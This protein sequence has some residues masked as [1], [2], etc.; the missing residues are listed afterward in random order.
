MP[1]LRRLWGSPGG[2]VATAQTLAANALILSINMLTGIITARALGP[3]GRGE[4]A[5][6]TMWPQLLAMT[7]TLGWPHALIYHLKRSPADSS[8]LFS[9]ALLLATGLGL[10]S[11]VAGIG[12]LPFWLRQYPMPVIRFA[13][14]VMLAAPLGQLTLLTTA[15]LQAREQFVALNRM[16]YLTPLASLVVLSALA[17]TRRLTPFTSVLAILLPGV[18]IL[19][20]MLALLCRLYRPRWHGLRNAY[21]QL[22]HY[23]M[24][25]YG[26]DLL[27]TLGD[28]VDQ[29]IVVGL[30]APAQMGMYVVALSLSRI[31]QLSHSAITWVLFPKAIGL[32]ADEV[33]ALTGRAARASIGLSLLGATVLSLAAPVGLGV[34]YGPRFLDALPVFRILLFVIVLDGTTAVLAQSFMALGRPEIVTTMEGIGLGLSTALL[35][36]LAP[37]CGLVG[38]GVALLA[39]AVVRFGLTLSAYPFILKS[40]LPRL[41]PCRADLESLQHILQRQFALAGEADPPASL[42]QVGGEL[43]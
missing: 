18:P 34:L 4:Q 19:G 38:A 39:A 36:L 26:N 25:A 12:L 22:L 6:M 43:D 29:V 42:E 3:V 32:P 20:W 7:V 35:L 24:R 33:I 23:G 13:Q 1:R 17:A 40:S 28:Q 30:L 15:V 14:G 21:R 37:R 5:A 41:F 31:L 9:A 16:R 2:F 8:K 27:G 11:A 10:L